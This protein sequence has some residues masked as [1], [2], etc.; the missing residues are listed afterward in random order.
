MKQSQI[1][2]DVMGTVNNGIIDIYNKNVDGSLLGNQNYSGIS[3]PFGGTVNITGTLSMSN[4]N[5]NVNLTFDMTNCKI[6]NAVNSTVDLAMSGRLLWTGWYNGNANDESL[7]YQATGLVLKGT[8]HRTNYCDASISETVDYSSSQTITAPDTYQ[9]SGTING[10]QASWNSNETSGD[11]STMSI[12]PTSNSFPPGIGTGTVTVTA[13][14]SCQWTPVTS[15]A[16]WLTVSSS[17]TNT[18]GIVNYSLTVNTDNTIRTGQITIGSKIFT[19]TQAAQTCLYSIF[20]TANLAASNAGDSGSVELTVTSSTNG[21]SV[22]NCP[23]IAESNVDWITIDSGSSGS[24]DGTVSYTVLPNKTSS[25]RTGTISIADQTFTVKQAGSSSQLCSGTITGSWSGTCTYA[26]Y[27]GS[28]GGGF[29]M[30]I[31]ANGVV[32][33]SGSNGTTIYG[34]ESHTGGFSATASGSGGTMSWSG[35]F[36]CSGNS[37]SGSGSWGGTDV[38]TCSGGWSGQGTTAQ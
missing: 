28:S 18:G 24:G 9:D 22:S 37:L 5:T 21:G 38:A 1:D 7:N 13:S 19:V 32:T 16:S 25:Q 8:D 6:R 35:T 2:T 14:S 23:W 31:D 36:T 27:S 17:T 20:P 15:D 30:N 33:G 10:R 3:C 11:C 12:S 29:T 26:G 34:T 4:D